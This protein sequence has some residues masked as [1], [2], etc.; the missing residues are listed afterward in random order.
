MC[1]VIGGQI[2]KVYLLRVT[3]V[4]HGLLRQKM[5]KTLRITRVE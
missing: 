1:E 3:V 5:I 2:N 4:L